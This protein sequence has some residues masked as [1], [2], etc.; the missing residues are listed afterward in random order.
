MSLS[1]DIIATYRKP[2][3]VM[4]RL[5]DHDRREGRLLFYLMLACGLLF[6]AQWPRLM[7]QAT[8][9]L[10]LDGLL[11]GT[12]FALVFVAPLVLYGL[13]GLMALVLRVL[14]GQVDGF[15]VRL[16]LF[17]ALLSSAP[18]ALLQAALG[19]VSPIAAQV[20]GPLVLLA[21]VVI[22]FA[23]LRTVLSRSAPVSQG[24]RH[25]APR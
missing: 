6:V 18:L 11:A 24:D 5:L 10:P 16:A 23:G 1:A 2:G 4:A 9:E 25:A 8:A 22:L 15:G 17:W 7:R 19:V 14:R 13:G 21:F 3:R 20:V 12:L